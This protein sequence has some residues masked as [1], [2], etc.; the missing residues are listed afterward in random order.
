MQV[1]SGF[2]VGDLRLEGCDLLVEEEMLS[3]K[4]GKQALDEGANGWGRGG[5]I[6]G[7]NARWWSHLV[8]CG[9]FADKKADVKSDAYVF[10]S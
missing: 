2:E 9:S 7:R 6:D 8:H 1:E 5:P 10:L 3:L 4:L